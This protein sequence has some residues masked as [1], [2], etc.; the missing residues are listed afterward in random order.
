MAM[1]DRQKR[2]VVEYVIDFNGTQAAIRAGYAQNSASESAFNNLNN[3]MVQEAV[4]ERVAE[5]ARAK[6]LTVEWVLDQWRQIASADPNELTWFEYQCCRHCYGLNFEYQ[7]TEFEYRKHVEG[8]HEH[9]C[10][11]AKCEQPCKDKF[12]RLALGGFGFT[13]HK[14]PN[15]DCPICNGEGH[16]VPKV[17]DTR[18]VSGP[19]RRLYAGIKTT[20]HGIEVKMRDQ[21]AALKN[22]AQYLGML[23]DK[24]ELAGP[25]GGPIVAQNITAKDLTDDQLAAILVGDE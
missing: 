4:A 19:A 25:G 3:S 1:N 6:A 21:D 2:F 18:R 17:A 5:I 12:P 14:N 24:K 7:W 9:V 11:A 10:R 16:Q 22:I 23:V 15:P 13:P 8:C 20:Q